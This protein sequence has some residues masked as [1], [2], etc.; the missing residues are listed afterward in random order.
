MVVGNDGGWW[1]VETVAGWWRWWLVTIVGTG[2]K[3]SVAMIVGGGDGKGLRRWLV[4]L[5]GW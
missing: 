4:V 3:W 1:W 2:V 5:Y